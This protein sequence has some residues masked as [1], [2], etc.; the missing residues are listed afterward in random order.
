MIYWS[1][2]DSNWIFLF[3]FSE[4]LVSLLFFWPS[5]GTC[6]GFCLGI[7]Y[8]SV[9]CL[10]EGLWSSHSFAFS[11][12]ANEGRL[13]QASF[14]VLFFRSPKDRPPGSGAAAA[15]GRKGRR[16]R[17][18]SLVPWFSQKAKVFFQLVWFFLSQ[19]AVI[20]FKE[21]KEATFK[22]LAVFIGV[23]FRLKNKSL[24]LRIKTIG[25]VFLWQRP[26]YSGCSSLQRHQG[27]L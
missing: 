3:S 25:A 16:R 4:S 27:V 8:V 9:I 26:R 2:L 5:D 23:L 6:L 20:L 22:N 24:L 13:A 19:K 1:L 15:W 21:T 10:T 14:A 11:L 18:S 12:W 17:R 7:F